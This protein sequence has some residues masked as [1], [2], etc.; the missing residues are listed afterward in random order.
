MVIVFDHFPLSKLN[1]PVELAQKHHNYSEQ[2]QEANSDHVN[3]IHLVLV[4]L[5]L[6]RQS[7]FMLSFHVG[8]RNNVYEKSEE[9]EEN[10][11]NHRILG[12]LGRLC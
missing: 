2:S 3:E 5:M 6:F 8:S 12:E 10:H 4:N 7:L 1:S 11:H 9:I